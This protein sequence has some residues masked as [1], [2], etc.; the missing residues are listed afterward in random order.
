MMLDDHDQKALAFAHAALGQGIRE[1]EAALAQSPGIGSSSL[2]VAAMRGDEES[3]RTLLEAAPSS[4]DLPLGPDWRPLFLLAHSHYARPGAPGAQGV[5]NCADLLLSLGADPTLGC[6]EGDLPG[7]IATALC[8]AA[9]TGNLELCELLLAR[10][11]K[12]DDGASLFLAVAAENWE[13]ARVLQ[14]GGAPL[15]PSAAANGQAVLHWMLDFRCVRPAVQR[16]LDDGADPNLRVGKYGETALHVAVRRR[17]IEL[18]DPLLAA[19]AEIDAE[20]TGGLSAWRHALRRPFEEICERLAERGSSTVQTPGDELAAALLAS[21]MDRARAKLACAAVDKW[22][23]EER[24]VLCDLAS[25]GNAEATLFLLDAGVDI[26]SRG[27]DEGTA[28]HQTAWFGQ[29]E[30]ARLLVE[31]GA[32]LDARCDIHNSTPLAWVAHGSRWAGEAGKR[33]DDY[34]EIAELLMAAGAPL[35]GPSDQHDHPQL[36]QASDRV[37]AVLATSGTGPAGPG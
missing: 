4:V 13:C 23:A 36:A 17:R 3:V 24:R 7:G 29:P 22:C 5:L 16:L 31:R 2:H 8:G 20:T 12:A 26:E 33:Q 14:E 19:G 10:G 30:V 6:A 37:R 21:D 34:V 18:I 35:P 9:G 25:Q 11:A 1:A 15:G 32:R 27:L 28:L